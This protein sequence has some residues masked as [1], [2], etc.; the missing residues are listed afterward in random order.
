MLDFHNI[1][2][3][4]Y[5]AMSFTLAQKAD[6]DKESNRKNSTKAFEV[7]KQTQINTFPTKSVNIPAHDWHH[8]Q[9]AGVGEEEMNWGWA[10]A[11]S[12]VERGVIEEDS[13]GVSVHAEG[14]E[15]WEICYRDAD[16]SSYC[17]TAIAKVE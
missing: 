3:A 5:N 15:E 16:P 11:C 8:W 13:D 6:H 14:V 10:F 1:W 4:W 9:Y 12:A 17:L 2:L 7:D